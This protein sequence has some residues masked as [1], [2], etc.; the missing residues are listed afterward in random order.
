VLNRLVRDDFNPLRQVVLTA[1]RQLQSAANLQSEV[2]ILKYQN[3]HVQIHARLSE[4][5][6][7]VLTDSYYPGWKVFVDG[8][9]GKLLRANYFFRAVELPAGA[10]QVEFVY[11]P[12][13]FKIGLIVSLLTGVFLIAVPLASAIRRRRLL[14]QSARIVA[15][16][17]ARAPVG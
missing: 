9:Q 3:S 17:P 4:P 11:D 6:I 12:L 16:Q 7:L 15:H 1:P 14:R 10:H 2:F 8:T 5:G 13:S